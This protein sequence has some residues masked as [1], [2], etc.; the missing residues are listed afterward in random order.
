MY[1]KNISSILRVSGSDNDC[2][3]ISNGLWG[4]IDTTPLYRLGRVTNGIALCIAHQLRDR[5]PAG[6]D[7]PMSRDIGRVLRLDLLP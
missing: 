5:R 7:S 6:E 1:A 2:L 3:S 4:R